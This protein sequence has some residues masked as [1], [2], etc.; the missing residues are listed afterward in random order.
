M[1]PSPELRKLKRQL[2]RVFKPDRPLP[3]NDPVYVD[4]NAA[5]GDNNIFLLG[6]QIDDSDEEKTCRLYAG[7]RGVGKSTELLRLKDYLEQLD[8]FVVYF[9]VDEEDIE[10]E[11]TEYTDIL[12]ACTRNLLKALENSAQ[13][14]L[15]VKWLKDCGT[16]I[17]DLL[18]TEFD[19]QD[20]KVDTVLPLLGKLTANLKAVPS[21]RRKIRDRVNPYTVTLLKALNEFIDGAKKNLPDSKTRLAII[22]DNL[23]RIVPKY[24]DNGRTNHDEIFLDR[25]AQLKGLNCHVVYT[26]PI[27]MVHSNRIIDLTENYENVQVLPMVMVKI[28]PDEK[29]YQ[30]G[31]DKIK[32]IIRIRV[33]SMEGN[34]NLI[35]DI[36]DSEET[37]EGICRM[38]GGHIRHIM[39]LMKEAIYLTQDFPITQKYALLA[40]SKLRNMYQKAIKSHQWEILAKVN[41][42]K[43]IENEEEYYNLLFDRCILTYHYLNIEANKF[44][45]WYDIHPVIA[46][47]DE[48]KNAFKNLDSI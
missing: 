36:F 40:I 10:V 21:E 44:E 33:E 47:I 27:S 41:R 3:A 25:H 6:E 35:P 9:A 17:K 14:T 20:I 18:T 30:E 42:S 39:Y 2:N 11:D 48:F 24:R 13:P 45:E 37:L 15:L 46:G 19:L 16:D 28:P 22:V 26:I 7:H 43:N 38:S 32:D 29:P 5:R 31:I 1:I 4:C 23:D 34:Y 8:Y 12:L